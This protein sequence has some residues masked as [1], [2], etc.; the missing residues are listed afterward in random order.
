MT[1]R[2][3]LDPPFHSAFNGGGVRNSVA[4]EVGPPRILST[5]MFHFPSAT[6][7]PLNR[8]TGPIFIGCSLALLRF[9]PI[10]RSLALSRF[11]GCRVERLDITVASRHEIQ[12][13]TTFKL[14]RDHDPRSPENGEE[15]RKSQ[16]TLDLH[17]H[18]G[19]RVRQRIG[20]T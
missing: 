3:I 9:I 13:G 18:L 7:T 20:K 14:N 2:Q 10:G 15:K 17:G 11:G 4:C 5:T 19:A 1:F 12:I 6:C 16:F 8:V